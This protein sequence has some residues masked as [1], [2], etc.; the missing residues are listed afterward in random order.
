MTVDTIADIAM[1]IIVLDA[2][3]Y[4]A[5]KIWF[6]AITVVLGLLIWYI[7]YLYAMTFIE[8]ASLKAKNYPIKPTKVCDPV[9]HWKISKKIC[10]Y[11]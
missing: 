2:L 10:K 9:N 3:N 7:L 4:Q 5:N 8:V 1:D 6:D 11:I